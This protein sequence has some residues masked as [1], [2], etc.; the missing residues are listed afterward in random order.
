MNYAY[1]EDGKVIQI[2]P[3]YQDVFPG[4]PFAERFSAEFVSCCIPVDDEAAV[5][6]GMVY[7]AEAGRFYYADIPPA[8]TLAQAVKLKTAEIN[9]A[10]NAAIVAG[11]DYNGKHYALTEEDQINIIS[12]LMLAQAGQDVPYH[13]DGEECGVYSAQEFM[14]VAQTGTAFKLHHTTYCN[15]LKLQVRAMTDIDAVMAVRYG[16]TR[17]DGDFAGHY[18]AVMTALQGDSV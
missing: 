16:E 12:L 5:L 2:E 7:D 17:L 3:E 10:C 11:F 13:A 14:A 6:P 18:S 15:L 4:V 8:D 1:I 9:A